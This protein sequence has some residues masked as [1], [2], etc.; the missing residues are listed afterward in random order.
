MNNN[1]TKE[2]SDVVRKK[3]QYMCARLSAALIAAL[4]WAAQPALAQ[5]LPGSVGTGGTQPRTR[6]YTGEIRRDED[7]KEILDE[8]E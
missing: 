2:G 3:A 7:Q 5:E 6:Y 1:E 4:I 8:R